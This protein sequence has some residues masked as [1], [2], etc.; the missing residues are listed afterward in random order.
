VQ[1]RIGDR[2]QLPP[3]SRCISRGDRVFTTVY[4]SP[5]RSRSPWRQDRHNEQA[6]VG[7]QVGTKRVR[8]SRGLDVASLVL[9]ER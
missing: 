3:F 9:G 1:A 4:G 2:M 6:T 7:D 8:D 5:S